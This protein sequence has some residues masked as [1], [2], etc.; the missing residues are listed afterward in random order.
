MITVPKLPP[1]RGYVEIEVNGIRTYRNTA[2]GSIVSPAD[3]EVSS[4]EQ[5]KK[6]QEENIRLKAKMELQSQQYAFLE[7]CIL[8]M[9]DIVYA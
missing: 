8:E 7:D 4:E 2:T 5:I 9:A 1:K 6:L 3:N